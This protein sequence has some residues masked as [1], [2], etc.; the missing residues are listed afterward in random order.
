MLAASGAR[1]IRT[2]GVDGG[3]TY[4]RAFDDLNDVTLLANGR[5]T[6]DKQFAKFAE[7]LCR[8]PDLIFGPLN[9]QIPVRIFIGSDETQLLGAKIFEYSVR[10]ETCRS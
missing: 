2:L 4:D 10:A 1:H 3:N 6:F 5:D 8:Y 9:M 7:T